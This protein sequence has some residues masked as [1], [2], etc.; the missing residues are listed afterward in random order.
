MRLTAKEALSAEEYTALCPYRRGMVNG[1]VYCQHP[2]GRAPYC[3]APYS[4]GDDE[5]SCP[6]LRHYMKVNKDD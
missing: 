5:Y 4:K 6:R 2:Y 1:N 3:E